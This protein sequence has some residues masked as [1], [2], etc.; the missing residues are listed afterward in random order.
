MTAQNRFN[1]FFV[2]H[3]SR[4]LS[5]NDIKRDDRDLYSDPRRSRHQVAQKN[6]G[7][8]PYQ[9]CSSSNVINGA[10]DPRR[11]NR[12]PIMSEFESPQPSGESSESKEILNC[13]DESL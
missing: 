2:R 3:H 13:N 12:E 5:S 11:Q 10:L 1:F 7:S 4:R 8:S 6:E 9:P